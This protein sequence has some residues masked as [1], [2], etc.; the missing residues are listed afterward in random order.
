MRGMIN[1]MA[2]FV[3]FLALFLAGF[4]AAV[5][6]ISAVSAG[7][8][9]AASAASV[10]AEFIPVTLTEALQVAGELWSV[11]GAWDKALA[12]V[13][14][15]FFAMPQALNL[16]RGVF[17]GWFARRTWDEWILDNWPS[18]GRVLVFAWRLFTAALGRRA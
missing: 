8:V 11:M 13:L 12:A 2:G 6:S 10:P 9:A 14:L 16:L 4:G 3:L 1:M 7:E 15:A 5:A 17:P 18:F